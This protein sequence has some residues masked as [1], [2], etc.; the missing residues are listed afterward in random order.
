MPMPNPHDGEDLKLS[1]RDIKAI[2]GLIVET[3]TMLETIDSMNKKPMPLFILICEIA[4][5]GLDSMSD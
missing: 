4:L 5:R 1:S 2:R 3:I